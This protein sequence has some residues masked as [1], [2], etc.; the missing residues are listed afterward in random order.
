MEPALSE[1]E[2]SGG[3]RRFCLRAG[4]ARRVPQSRNPSAASAPLPLLLLWSKH[5]WQSLH[6]RLLAFHDHLQWLIAGAHFKVVSGCIAGDL[7]HRE[8]RV[9]SFPVHFAFVGPSP[10]AAL[11]SSARK[12]T[13]A[14]AVRL[15]V[16]VG[17]LSGVIA[18]DAE[19][20][21]RACHRLGV[22][23]AHQSKAAGKPLA[24][25]RVRELSGRAERIR[26]RFPFG[27]PLTGEVGELLVLRPRLGRTRGG[28]RKNCCHECKSE[29]NTGCDGYVLLHAHVVL[30]G[31]TFGQGSTLNLAKSLLLSW[32]ALSYHLCCASTTWRPA[33]GRSRASGSDNT[34]SP[35]TPIKD[36]SHPA[37]MF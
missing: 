20:G 3:A 4:S 18:H 25:L 6:P 10:R 27:S 21:H 14:I 35:L 33:A 16:H 26:L 11:L 7:L 30:L 28:L 32:S 34:D 37:A 19:R 24:R 22:R 5:K 29:Q 36:S 12:K 15:E 23:V 1:V 13:L 31:R 9:E 2:G 17:L 8:S